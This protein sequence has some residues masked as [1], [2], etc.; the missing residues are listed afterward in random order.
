VEVGG[1][2][3]GGHILRGT[4]LSTLHPFPVLPPLACSTLTHIVCLRVGHSFQ[5]AGLWPLCPPLLTPGQL[6][7]ENDGA[8]VRTDSEYV[9]SRHHPYQ[10]EA[11]GRL[12]EMTPTSLSR[13]KPFSPKVN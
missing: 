2:Q 7:V 9:K 8:N 3:T 13:R 6:K 1:E 12:P 5:K 10:M 4:P 11:S